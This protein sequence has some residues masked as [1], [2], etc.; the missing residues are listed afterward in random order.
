M[1]IKGKWKTQKTFNSSL[2]VKITSFVFE[3][4]IMGVKTI[5]VQFVERAH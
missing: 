4:E 2:R 3:L 1:C 5:M